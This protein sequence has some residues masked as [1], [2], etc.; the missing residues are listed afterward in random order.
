[1]EENQTLHAQRNQSELLRITASKNLTLKDV[2][3]IEIL[4][5]NNYQIALI[6]YFYPVLNS[7]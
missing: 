6:E 5:G 3:P 4:L 7:T 2:F 1:M